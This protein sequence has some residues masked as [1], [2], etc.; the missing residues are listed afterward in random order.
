MPPSHDGLPQPSAD[1][2]PTSRWPRIYV[3][4]L[5]QALPHPHADHEVVAE[6]DIGWRRLTVVTGGPHIAVGR[7]VAVALPGGRVV[8]AHSAV[9]GSAS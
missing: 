9:P 8:D 7:K 6:V 5:T 2:A 1:Q 3:G 4:V